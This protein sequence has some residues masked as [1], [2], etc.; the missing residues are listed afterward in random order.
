MR[1]AELVTS[2]GTRRPRLFLE[3]PHIMRISPISPSL[4]LADQ[5]MPRTQARDALGLRFVGA[6]ATQP[7]SPGLYHKT[8]SGTTSRRALPTTFLTLTID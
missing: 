8:G 1:Q 4:A 7:V 6:A 5:R 3:T 2:A